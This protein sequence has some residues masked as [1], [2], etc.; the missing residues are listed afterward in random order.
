[1]AIGHDFE[2]LNVECEA[3]QGQLADLT[4]QLAKAQAEAQR[5]KEAGVELEGR[6]AEA[7]RD[8][9]AL[10]SERDALTGELDNRNRELQAAVA[11]ATSLN[12]AVSDSAEKNAAAAAH[13]QKDAAELKERLAKAWAR[14][15][16]KIDTSC[17]CVRPD[18]PPRPA[19]RK[20]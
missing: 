9:V 11:D 5:L 8:R 2:L 7:E 13:A 19:A 20:R 16:V 17:L 4:A 10:S 1:M 15:D 6:L 14:A 3:A 12:S 18:T